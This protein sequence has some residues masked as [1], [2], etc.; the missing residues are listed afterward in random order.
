MF[1]FFFFLSGCDYL[2][3]FSVSHPSPLKPS[4]PEM[5]EMTRRYHKNETQQLLFKVQ[6]EKKRL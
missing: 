1:R 3:P 6:K 2:K 5:H 4:Q